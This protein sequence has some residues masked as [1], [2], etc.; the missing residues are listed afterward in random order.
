MPAKRSPFKAE[1]A[2]GDRRRALLAL[3]D[4]LADELATAE[5]AAVASLS[6]QLV[7]VLNELDGIKVPEVSARD[8]LASRRTARRAAAKV[9][10]GAA[11]GDVGGPGGG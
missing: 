2:S 1:V 4:R 3:R 6:R 10:G 7:N 8:D 5:G 11:G 9:Q